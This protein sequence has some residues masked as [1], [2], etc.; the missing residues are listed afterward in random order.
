[1]VRA[2][3]EASK[4]TF[5]VGLKTL[6]KCACTLA[7]APPWPGT[8]VGAGHA[9][10]DKPTTIHEVQSSGVSSEE[11]CRGCCLTTPPLCPRRA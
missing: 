10:F 2:V 4:G 11:I 8:R 9:P 3:E 5:R 6:D 7:A 1:M